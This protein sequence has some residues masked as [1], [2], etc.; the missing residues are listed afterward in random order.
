[1]VLVQS[2]GNLEA[3]P[4]ALVQRIA[5]ANLSELM[6]VWDGRSCE[7]W[8]QAPQLYRQLTRRLLAQ[9]EPLL[10]Y[11]VV[12]EGL[13]FWPKDV[14]LRQM[15]GL[16]L[17]RSGAT[18][19][20]NAVLQELRREGASDEETLGML[21]RTY[22]DLALRAESPE[23]E[24][25]LKRAAEIYGEA[26]EKTGGY[27]TGINAA[28]M[29]LLMGDSTRACELSHQVKQQCLEE[30]R[31]ARGDSYWQYAA[32]GESCLICC[33]WDEAEQWYRR[34]AEQG[35][36]RFGDLQSSRRNA[37][38][39]LDHWKETRRHIEQYLHV[40]P[41]IVF[42]GHM[43]DR[44]D[45][46]TPRFPQKDE[47]IVA[48]K[49]RAEIERI[50]PGSGFSSAACG[51]DILFLEAMLEYGAE[52]SVVLPYKREQFVN[53]SVDI[54]PGSQWLARFHEVLRKAAR[55][56]T[57]SP[58]RLEIGGVS[59]EF[60]N[61]MLIGLSSI[62]R[63]Q[64]D[65]DLVPLVV[66]NG[67]TGDGAG[68]TASAVQ[69]W[70]SLGLKPVSI[71]LL[72]TGDSASLVPTQTDFPEQ[73]T[74]TTASR[75]QRFTSRVVSILFAD[76]VGF[77]KLGEAEVPWFVEHFLGAIATL[78]TRY[79]RSIL[80]RNTW[81]DGVYFVFSDP[82]FAGDFG[83]ELARVVAG[84]DWRQKGFSSALN[85]RIGLH[86]GPVYEFDDP[87]TGH[88]SYSGTH[89]SR[90]ARIEPITPPGQVYASESFAAL[91]AAHGAK[92]FTCD[93]IGQT[94]MAKGY[95][96]FPTY[97]VRAET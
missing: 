25:L 24:T 4:E 9:G 53:D 21:G 82:A 59:Y 35:K 7:D 33:D 92:S 91:A 47:Q 75:S 29:N 40:P 34:A 81:G 42:A 8:H 95:G 13:N 69:K 44:S 6:V 72:A 79:E 11:D 22:K 94:A 65:T 20:A 86:A 23:R 80:A 76:A 1:M 93:Y 56:I 43:I 89:V 66:W 12:A 54:I 49:I 52:V 61:E 18:E 64:L 62:R 19:K 58:E 55:V 57:A 51:S 78:A 15:Q 96:S 84:T 36:R 27:W 17:S 87:I 30:A 85:L 71:D 50:K 77:S 39:I 41:V 73:T 3:N 60:C 28:T 5:S 26:Y 67:Q 16:A 31:N 10:A 70:K 48:A 46:E 88:R 83:L 74:A 63:R 32:L 68:G 90:A 97:H 14:A 2:G 38:L 37:R 45:R